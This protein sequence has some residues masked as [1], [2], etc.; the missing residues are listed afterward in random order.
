MKI[1]K[2][3]WKSPFKV[4]QFFST[5]IVLAV[6][7]LIISVIMFF[8]D[9]KSGF[10]LLLFSAGLLYALYDMY[11][12]YGVQIL[13]Q[14]V[15]FGINHPQVQEKLMKELTVP[16]IVLDIHGEFL[17]TN[18]AFNELVNDHVKNHESITELFSEI[19]SDFFAQEKEKGEF[20]VRYE[21]RNYSVALKKAYF[22]FIK[23]EFEKA[24]LS[25]PE[26]WVYAVYVLDE[27]ELVKYRNKIE[28]E[29]LIVGLIYIDN[30]DEVL[31]SIEEIRRS[32]NMA[33]LDRH[34]TKYIQG[35]GGIVKK[36]EADKYLILIKNKDLLQM[37][38]QHFVILDKIKAVKI[39]SSV[40]PT[41]VPT[42]SMGFG[43]GGENYAQCFEYARSAIDMALGRGGDQVVL[44]SGDKFKYYGGKVQA[45][46]K[47]TR[48]KARMK[49]EVLRSHIEVKD[50]V[51]IMGHR[52]SDT[53]CIGAAAGMYRAARYSGKRAYIT[54]NTITRSTEALI[55]QFKDNK[56]YE[57]DMFIDNKTAMEITDENTLLIIV[58]VNRPS[59]TECPDL[60]EKAGAIVIID[61]HRLTQETV[62]NAASSYVETFASSA[63]EM[64][65]E[66]LQ[67]YSDKLRIQREEAD[68]MLAGI[69]V[70]TNNFMNKTNIRTFEAA[71]FLR[72][73]GADVTRVH[74][75]F[76]EEIEDCRAR[77]QVISS[78]ELFEEHYLIGI[79]PNN[80]KETPTIVAA[81]AANEMLDIKGIQGTFV[82]TEY[83][84]LIYIS[85]RSVEGGINVQR[86][87]ELLG[88]GGHLNLAGAQLRDSDPETAVAKLKAAILQ[89]K[90]NKEI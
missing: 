42:I 44:K 43:A 53:D 19:P 22:P 46:E 30:Y 14:L 90:E 87:M 32:L 81:Q 17:W 63:S 40:N 59:Y 82:V 80:T 56:E 20:H 79:C 61:H 18:P 69:I 84:D 37:E 24:S 35:F 65:A 38:E 77:A 76:K 1:K 33:V 16:Y 64:V 58:D 88:G 83:Q 2:I 51:V 78:A 85:A 55:A 27:T 9:L 21:G 11:N 86:A 29:E 57:P 15:L 34:I 62:P 67:Y 31:E 54:V 7:M 75:M 36:L 66:I 89:M 70:D 12:K 25:Q 8:I 72:K 6:G 45:Q 41:I 68:A 39:S 26:E 49:A 5:P 71:A 74:R 52:L 47:T 13:K 4:N 50:K 3:Q 48:V 60:I 28:E 10:I 73:N 23:D